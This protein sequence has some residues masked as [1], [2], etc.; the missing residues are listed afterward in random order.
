MGLASNF[1][2]PDRDSDGIGYR[3]QRRCVVA[4]TTVRPNEQ[5][6]DVFGKDLGLMSEVVVT[7]RKVGADRQFWSRLAHDEQKFREVVVAV[8]GE[9]VEPSTTFKAAMQIMRTRNVHGPDQ[10][11][12][13][14]GVRYTKE[15]LLQLADTFPSEETL[16]ACQDTHIL[17]AGYPLTV[18]EICKHMKQNFN[19]E[20]WH[21]NEDFARKTRVRLRWLL[22]RKTD[23][24]NSRS[25]TYQAQLALLKPNESNSIFCEV[26]YGMNIHFAETGERLHKTYYVRCQDVTSSGR[27]VYVGDFDQ[28]GLCVYSDSDDYYK[29]DVGL[30]ASRNPRTV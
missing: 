28:S 24:P 23:V 7:G 2:R 22:L 29:D 1:K 13:R 3:S 4:K 25:K 21:D 15:E 17:V 5:H 27:R 11:M 16:R 10:I 18:L 12:K 9:D 14:F 26:V 6:E 20:D 19:N 8:N 30:A